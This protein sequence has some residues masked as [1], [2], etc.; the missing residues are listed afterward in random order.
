MWYH[1][2]AHYGGK[3]RCWW[4]RSRDGLV[5][6]VLVP[7]AG[8]QVQAVTR[9]GQPAL[10]NFAAVSYLTVHKTDGKLKRGERGG[11]P[12]ELRD[13]DFLAAN[14]ATKEFVDEIRVL[15]AATSSQSLVQTSL[16]APLNQI[17]VIMKFDDP[18]LD[19]AYEGV[20]QPLGQEFGYDVVRVDAIQ[21]SGS[22]SQQILQNIAE[23]RLVFADLTGQRPNCYYEAG[24]AHA[25][26]KE[27]IL[28]IREGEE[29]HFDLAGYR[30]IVWET[31]AKLRGGAE[32]PTRGD[33]IRG[34]SLSPRLAF[35]RA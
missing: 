11:I 16:K 31:E 13:K 4:N 3:R 14:N 27:L 10:F 5:A 7:L 20:I 15:S 17:F 28:S 6:K 22:I 34:L 9:N 24:F 2:V 8:Q 12:T 26:G 18:H 19:S 23:S 25:L 29:I 33:C 32:G 30:F 21:D 35:G 1:A